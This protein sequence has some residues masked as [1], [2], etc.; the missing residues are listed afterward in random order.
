MVVVR[1]TL[2]SECTQELNLTLPLKQQRNKQNKK[3]RQRKTFFNGFRC[4]TNYL[5]SESELTEAMPYSKG[6]V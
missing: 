3:G 6:E 5:L 1:L 4:F 2:L